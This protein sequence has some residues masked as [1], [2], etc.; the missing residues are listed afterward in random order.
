MLGRRVRIRDGYGRALK[1]IPGS[2]ADAYAT[3]SGQI[4]APCG[5]AVAEAKDAA[6]EPKEAKPKK[7]GRSRWRPGPN[8]PWRRLVINYK[9]GGN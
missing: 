5:G 4:A 7:P 6:L 8:R 2:E 3:P 1:A 9:K